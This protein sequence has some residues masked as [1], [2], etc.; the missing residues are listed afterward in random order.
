MVPTPPGGPP[1]R[2]LAPSENS[3]TPEQ[4]DL[5]ENTPPTALREVKTSGGSSLTLSEDPSAPSFVKVRSTPFTT[6]LPNG[7][8]G[9]GET[10]RVM[11]TGFL[12]W[13]VGL[14]GESGPVGG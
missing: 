3:G 11:G 1:S 14:G 8:N 5:K 13:S 10:D 2:G 9:S 12:S 6:S 7:P 4:S